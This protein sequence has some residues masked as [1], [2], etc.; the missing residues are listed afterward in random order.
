MSKRIP[1]LNIPLLQDLYKPNFNPL[2]LPINH[3]PDEIPQDSAKVE[4]R[5]K[6]V[7]AR[8]FAKEVPEPLSREEAAVVEKQVDQLREGIAQTR[9]RISGMQRLIE[10]QAVP[11][12]QPELNFSV[13][14]KKKGRLRRAIK[15]AFGIKP[16]AL[17]YSMYKAALKAKRAI[18]ESEA[19]G[20]TSG[21]WED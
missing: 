19:E 21:N 18:E 4:R 1:D 6:E 13:D 17:T 15:K 3:P 2:D 11:E 12:G 14:L 9:Q 10:K 20:Y 16:D 7:E 8:L 5:V